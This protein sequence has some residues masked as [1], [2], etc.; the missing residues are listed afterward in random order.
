[1]TISELY[2]VVV[3]DYSIDLQFENKKWHVLISTILTSGKDDDKHS[4][5]LL[6]T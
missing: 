4:G 3:D 2:D 6:P 1:M 5:Y